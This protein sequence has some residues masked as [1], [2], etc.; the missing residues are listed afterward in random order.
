[1]TPKMLHE[2]S[3]SDEGSNPCCLCPLK[4][5]NA[6]TN[7]D[8][9]ASL[10]QASV[11]LYSEEYIFK[12][13]ESK[14]CGYVGKSLLC[15]LISCLIDIVNEIL[16]PLERIYHNRGYVR[17]L[18]RRDC[19]SSPSNHG[20]LGPFTD[21]HQGEFKLE[22]VETKPL[23]YEGHTRR[24]VKRS[25]ATM[26]EYSRKYLNLRHIYIYNLLQIYWRSNLY[27]PLHRSHRS[28]ITIL[29]L[30]FRSKNHPSNP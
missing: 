23:A 10:I 18:A 3:L 1:M 13:S 5:I 8:Q 20:A 22:G 19:E 26:S 24:P 12:C 11:G 2:H 7:L 30:Q 27:L 21:A 15:L 25:Y 9:R 28:C 14:G 6:P 17:P 4:D 29:H 16:A